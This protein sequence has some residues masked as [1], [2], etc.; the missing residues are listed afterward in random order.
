MEQYDPRVGAYIEKSAMFAKPV[1]NH[2]RQLVHQ[3]SPLITETIKWGFPFFEYKGAVCNMAAFKQHCSMG[4]WKAALLNDPN[5][6]INRGDEPSAGSFGRVTTIADLPADE[7]IADFI[8]QAIILNETGAKGSMKP[9]APKTEIYVPDYFTAALAQHP[10]A[11]AAFGAFSPSHRKEYLEWII[12][13]KTDATRQ[14]RMDTAIEWMEEG[15]SRNW[16]YK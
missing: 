13:A 15:K 11:K 6:I 12:D 4:F 1:L 5:G 14:K 8:K 9:A 10:K 3:T 16:K 7:V 2:I